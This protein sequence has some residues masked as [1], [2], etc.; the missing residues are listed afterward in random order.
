MTKIL[1]TGAGGAAGVAAIQALRTDGFDVYA[2]DLSGNAAGL[3]LVDRDHRLLLPRGDAPEYAATLLERCVERD[4]ALVIPTVDCELMPVAK[5]RA[6]L[7]A[8][9]V[10]ALVAPTPSLKRC[11]DKLELAR[12]ASA[13][14]P[15]PRTA[16]FDDTFDPTGWEF[17]VIVK[18]RTGSGGRGVQRVD[19]VA[20]LARVPRSSTL[21]V[22]QFA[23]GLEYS[24]DVLSTQLGRVVA[25]VPRLRLKVDSGV[26]VAGCTVREPELEEFAERTASL[27]GLTGVANIQFRRDRQQRPLLLEVNPRLPGT[28]PLTI[29]AGVNMPSFAVRDVLGLS[30]PPIAGYR[31]L[32]MVRTWTEHY[33]P[34]DDL[35]IPGVDALGDEFAA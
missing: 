19:D 35:P 20:A 8:R 26:A 34:I 1:I 15:T 31:E 24:V 21:I 5:A 25:A 30:L 14:V 16:I 17:P 9:G 2:A 4:I 13:V 11:L 28:M 32:G 18:P 10:R 33:V 7:E 12:A 23:P 29:A 22:Q 6:R 3:Y 27:L